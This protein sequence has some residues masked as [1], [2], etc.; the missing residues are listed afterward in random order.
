M[1]SKYKKY[2]TAPIVNMAFSSSKNNRGSNK[3]IKLNNGINYS[4]NIPIGKLILDTCIEAFLITEKKEFLQT[5][6]TGALRSTMLK[7]KDNFK[8]DV[9]LKKILKRK[10]IM[11]NNE[12][13]VIKEIIECYNY[14]NRKNKI[15]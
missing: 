3:L 6:F 8:I 1:Y 12:G 11:Y 13:D 15:I 10:I 2:F 5:K 9:F 7:N 14:C 4:L